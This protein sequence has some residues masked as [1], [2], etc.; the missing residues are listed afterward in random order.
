[1]SGVAG[2]IA[3][4]AVVGAAGSIIAGN[5][6][7][8]ATRDASNAAIAQQQA[9]LQQQKELAAPYTGLGQ[10]AMG[11][12]EQ[13]LGIG[14]DGKINP[15]LAQQTLQNMPGYQFQQQQGQQQ[16]LAAAGAMGMGLSGNTLEALSKYNQGLAQST[17]QQELQNL[18]QPVQI[19]QAAAAGQ[20]ANI[21]Q[22]AANM[23]NIMMGQ[24]QN[25]ANIAIGQM[26]GIT[27]SIGNAMNQYTTMNTLK[28]LQGGGA[29]ASPYAA[30]VLSTPQTSGFGDI[31][32]GTT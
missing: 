30:P 19:G 12:Y 6:A 16:T 28:A 31:F 10:Q 21:G 4:A 14:K 23:G 24:G 18:L 9:A 2:A 8:S 11:A 13:L 25:Q 22:G 1:M 26:G 5:E 20:A 32:G 15:A 7:A 3:G 17:Y 27:G 29:G